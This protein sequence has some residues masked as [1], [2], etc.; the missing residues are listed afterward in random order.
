MGKKKPE[1]GHASGTQ[2]EVY[3]FGVKQFPMRKLNNKQNSCLKKRLNEICHINQYI[4]FN[5]L[6]EFFSIFQ[7]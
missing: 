2:K 1:V 7:R 4:K 6:R 3:C 5:S